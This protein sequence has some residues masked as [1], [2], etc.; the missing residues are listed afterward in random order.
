MGVFYDKRTLHYGFIGHVNI[1]D[2]ASVFALG[3]IDSTGVF[4]EMEAGLGPGFAYMVQNLQHLVPT[5]VI[6]GYLRILMLAD[7]FQTFFIRIIDESV[8][9]SAKAWAKF[10]GDIKCL[11]KMEGPFCIKENLAPTSYLNYARTESVAIF[12]CLSNFWAMFSWRNLKLKLL[13][14]KSA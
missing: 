6:F 7:D 10:I 12:R 8:K 14:A 11:F 13:V 2:G 4:R 3:K 9:L 1:A 5:K